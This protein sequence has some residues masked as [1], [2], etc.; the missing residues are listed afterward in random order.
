MATCPDSRLYG[1]V[2]RTAF[3]GPIYAGESVS[4]SERGSHPISRHTVVATSLTLRP[5]SF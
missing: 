5:M 2:M 1:Q 3:R 4:F